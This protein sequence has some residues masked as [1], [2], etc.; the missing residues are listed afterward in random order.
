MIKTLFKSFSGGEITPELFGRIELGKFQSGLRK[1]LN[2]IVLP[3]GPAVRRPGQ[4]YVLEAKDSTNNVRV[5]PFVFNAE[6]AMVLEFGHN[7][8]RFHTE[9]QTLLEANLTITAMTIASPGVFTIAA[10]GYLDG[11]WV[12]LSGFTTH[13]TLNNRYYKIFAKTANTFQLKDLHGVLINT[14]GLP[15]FVAGVAGRVYTIATT[16]A[17]ADLF[18]LHYVQSADVLTITHPS[19]QTTEIRRVGAANWTTAAVSFAPNITAPTGLAATPTV[20]VVG[21]PTLKY[22]VATAIGPDNVTESYAQTPVSANNDLSLAGNYNTVTWNAVATALR[23]N[24]YASSGGAYGYIGQVP[25]LSFVDNNV[26]PDLTKSYPQN[27]ITLNGSANNYPS[28]ATYFEQ[29]RIFAGTNNDQQTVFATRNGTE[30]NLTSSLPSQDDD[31]LKFRLASLQ[32]N[33]IRHLIPLTDLI[34]LT[35]S[36][37]WRIFADGAAALTPTSLAVKP[38]GYTGSS[39]VQPCVTVGS[40]LYVQ[41]QGSRIRELGY[42][43]DSTNFGYKSI[44]ISIM[45][46][47]LFNGKRVTDLA[48][49]RAPEQI[50]WAIR[51]DGVLLGMT[52]VPDQQ[53]YGWHQ[54]STDGLY[55]SVC[56]VPEGNE[57]ATY[58]VVQ[59]TING[60]T[61]RMIERQASRIFTDAEDGYFVDCGATYD[62]ASATTFYGLHHLEGETVQILADGAVET[63]QVVTAGTITLPFAASVVHFGLQYNSD[64][65]TLPLAVEAMQAAGQGTLKNI[66]AIHLRHT[67]TSLFKSG[68]DFTTMISNRSRLPTDPYGAPPSLQTAETRIAI[69]GNWNTDGFVCIRQDEPLPLTCLALVLEAQFGG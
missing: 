58:A 47:H 51:D 49:A 11:E 63:P 16:Y 55:E 22:Y 54:H 44:D 34:A 24:V 33:R 42:G 18:D 15:A 59:R 39:N 32:Q 65:Q 1:L 13:P 61:M 20:A 40:I 3:H 62:G 26:L 6:Q 60:R 68:A 21:N 57:D 36:G 43:G 50:L 31:A 37:E 12:Y 14:T 69:P 29:R 4:R 7:Y 27:L 30:S 41:A 2:F 19:Y 35:A 9:G 48:Y 45:A 46:P 67:Q 28:T 64:L 38:Q 66:D 17:S 8:I 53:V 10:H 25:G 52:Y 23:Y 56:T 5:I